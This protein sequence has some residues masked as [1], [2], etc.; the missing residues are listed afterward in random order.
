MMA[1][2]GVPTLRDYA[3]MLRDAWLVI[4]VATVLSASVAW[5]ATS[6][7]APSYTATSRV[8][9]TAP[10]PSSSRAALDG[11]RSSLVRVESYVQLAESEQV[12]RR[13]IVE[14]G[15]NI[16]PAELA[17]QVTVVATPGS[18]LIEIAATSNAAE[19]ARD[20]ANAL[21]LNLIQLVSEVDLGI[22]GPVSD[23][24]LIDDASVPSATS[25]LASNL[26]FGAGVGMFVSAVLVV[27]SGLRRDV[28]DSR[29]QAENIA[30]ERN[31]QWGWE[32][33]G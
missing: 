15:V 23:V 24:T 33:C 30:R 29:R 7:V 18:A 11:N 12:L 2:E 20:L 28:I 14:L 16:T 22:D 17:S 13:V 31:R 32:R 3:R 5:L 9:V 19:G 6:L 27:A 8:F 4:L 10:G 25:Q 21:A 26:V 1:P